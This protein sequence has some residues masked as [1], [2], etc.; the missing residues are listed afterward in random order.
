MAKKIIPD[1]VFFGQ[2]TVR[3]GSLLVW[4][5]PLLFIVILVL[6]L[7][8][9]SV[10]NSMPEKL[11]FK[12]IEDPENVLSVFELKNMF[13]KKNESTGFL[14]NELLETPFWISFFPKKNFNDE[15]KKV[16][17]ASR[18]ITKL[19]CWAIKNNSVEK[20]S[21]VSQGIG[22]GV[23]YKKGGW[24]LNVKSIG[25]D[26]ELICKIYFRGPARLE[27]K[28]WTNDSLIQEVSIF[29]HRKGFL[30]GG[31]T[32]L[33][34][35]V[36]LAAILTRTWVFLLYSV[37]LMCSLRMAALSGGW[38]V[39]LYGNTI[40]YN[41]VFAVRKISIAAY[42]SACCGLIFHLFKPQEMTG[43][44]KMVWNLIKFSALILVVLSVFAPYRIFLQ[45]MWPCVLFFPILSLTIIS[46]NFHQTK[47]SSSLFYL[48]S[49]IITLSG[50]V[51]EVVAAW[52]GKEFLISIIN[53]STITLAASLMAAMA[54]A[55]SLRSA[56]LQRA[57]A[58]QQTKVA[59]QKLERMFN[60]APSAMFSIN[61][62]GLLLKYNQ[63]FEQNYLLSDGSLLL[64]SLSPKELKKL[65]AKTGKTGDIVKNI[66]R[67]SQDNRQFKW[68][69]ITLSRDDGSV[70]GLIS[71]ITEQ[72]DREF[73][74]HH[75]ATHDALTGAL[76]RRGLEERLADRIF[77][78]KGACTIFSVDIRRFRYLNDAHGPGA[79]DHLL[80]ILYKELFRH[81][82]GYGEIARLQADNFIIL[83]EVCN[84][85]QAMRD[86]SRLLDHLKT[87]ALS[88]ERKQILIE[89]NIVVS[90]FRAA[91]NVQ[92]V[93]ETIEACRREAKVSRLRSPEKNVHRFDEV[94]TQQLLE[95]SRIAN[96]IG[97]QKLP[98]NLMLV[99][100]PIM[101]LSAPDQYLHAEIL[102]RMRGLSGE[103]LPAGDIIDACLS[104][105]R[106]SML[107]T[108]VLNTTLDW[109]NDN[110]NQL[111]GLQTISVNILPSSLNDENFL[112]ET[113]SLLKKNKQ[114]INKLCLE[115]TEVGALFN[116]QSVRGFVEKVR[117]MGVKI[118]LDDFGAGY[119]NFRYAIDLCADI[120][121]IDGSIITDICKNPQSMAVTRAIVGLAHD[122]GC[123]CVAE[124]IED[125]MTMV[126]LYDLEVDYVQG[127]LIS[128]PVV[129]ES[130]LGKTSAIQ[131]IDDSNTILSIENY[132][133]R[134]VAPKPTFSLTLVPPSSVPKNSNDGSGK[135]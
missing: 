65:C 81:L 89:M 133:E 74:L 129:L 51:N 34:V 17:L 23:S 101:S 46:K 43:F 115:I 31:L 79:A 105:G 7:I 122:L 114:I 100:Q 15:E 13:D 97:L 111:A 33:A 21:S 27:I 25:L 6:C 59:H 106:A 71:D 63:H 58:A 98:E 1:L 64:P 66:F 119:S 83:I 110:F 120:I 35:F 109:I 9:I 10:H 61:F 91:Q 22:N 103:P 125:S 44:F 70:M 52:L 32:L 86:C 131:F 134:Q 82:C 41:M 39:E 118:A 38:D 48:A 5:A 11:R 127:F 30:E 18:H 76:N 12:Q 36:M 117:A 116:V 3:S 90:E 50:S 57:I 104:Q 26:Q 53:S 77:K 24:I 96:R 40:P 121:K 16:E 126:A 80:K 95:Q 75:Q 102:L 78:S 99:V 28:K 4:V 92:E 93:L 14:R 8:N 73:A 94:R 85:E 72:K 68:Y 2:S 87:Q 20:I 56:Q 124:W 123:K 107:D 135:A 60:L 29:E 69:E 88:A 130:F 112:A 132:L 62:D 19:D 108:W 42:Y 84:S 37:W 67:E 128:K 54:V 45:V 113:L 47:S 55:E 49:L